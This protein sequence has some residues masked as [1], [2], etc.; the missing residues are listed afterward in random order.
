[1]GKAILI[2]ISTGIAMGLF[3]NIVFM[4]WAIRNYKRSEMNNLPP[5]INQENDMW[6][7]LETKE[8]QLC[9]GTG[10]SPAMIFGIKIRISCSD[11]DGT[12]RQ[13]LSFDEIVEEKE[14]KMEERA[15]L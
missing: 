11:C 13:I 2:I 7:E 6:K 9:L 14:R 8:C 5:G 1:M 12:G 10:K 3:A 4:C 15:E